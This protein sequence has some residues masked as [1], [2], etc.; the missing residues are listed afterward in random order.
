MPKC[1]SNKI[2]KQFALRH[3]C[4]FVNLLHICRTPIYKNTSGGL[5]LNIEKS[6]IEINSLNAKVANI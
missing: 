3:G 6:Q 1:D 2:A 5:L 4:S